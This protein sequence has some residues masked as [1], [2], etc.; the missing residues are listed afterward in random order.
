MFV[1]M[2]SLTMI[3]ELKSFLQANMQLISE[4]NFQKLY[5][6][7]ENGHEDISPLTEI[8]TQA[9][10]NPLLYL[11]EVPAKYAYYSKQLTKLTIPDH[12][13]R[14]LPFAFMGCDN[15]KEVILPASIKIIGG[16]A[17]DRVTNCRFIYRD[18]SSNFLQLNMYYNSFSP[19]AEIQC[20][21]ITA[22]FREI[23]DDVW[24]WSKI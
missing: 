7:Y 4:N 21:D 3:E 5:K 2:E 13:D 14:I 23:T 15:L 8:L 10:I 9:D 11:S 24:D 16:F 12:I 18:K 1:P 6:E 22:T 17:F 19:S 20:T